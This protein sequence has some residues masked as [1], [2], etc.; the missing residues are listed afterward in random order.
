MGGLTFPRPICFAIRQRTLKPRGTLAGVALHSKAIGAYITYLGALGSLK[1]SLGGLPQ[2]ATINTEILG[3]WNIPPL[4]PLYISAPG[5]GKG[6]SIY[7]R[8]A[9]IQ[10]PGGSCREHSPLSRGG[11]PRFSPTELNSRGSPRQQSRLLSLGAP[12]Y[13]TQRAK[14]RI[15][16][17]NLGGTL[18]SRGALRTTRMPTN[19]FDGASKRSCS[20][21]FRDP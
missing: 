4:R 12:C 5:P 15:S 6:A 10:N 9:P 18:L 19:P 3:S 7:H 20:A 2:G 11:I 1:P 14:S 13:N 21:T 16:L 17:K 8:R